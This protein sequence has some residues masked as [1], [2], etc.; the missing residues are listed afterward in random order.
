M[1]TIAKKRV[2]IIGAGIS[3]L[4][5]L[6]ECLAEGFDA[7]VL[8]SRAE[9]GGQWA[10]QAGP[11]EKGELQS[12][13]YDGVVLNSCRDTTA[14]SDFP[15]DP[16]RHGDYFSHREMHRYILDYA[17]HFG[18]H[19]HI[20]LRTKVL[21]CTQDAEGKW[22]VKFQEDGSKPQE[23]E[24]DVLIS[25][26][27]INS[28]PIIPDFKD[29]ESFRGEFLHSHYYRKPGRFEG[30]R[31]VLIGSGSAAIDLACELAPGCKE[32]HVITRRGTWVI[33]RYALGK[34]VE[35]WDS[36]ASQVWL[37]SSVAEWLNTT[38][39]NFVQG[40]HPKELQPD[41]K[42][43]QQNP[44]IRTEFI[45]KVRH[46]V[47]KV[48]RG[49][50]EN[51]LETGLKLTNGE[52]LG[53]DVII[54]CTGYKRE[55]P[56]LPGNVLSNA[57][58]PEFEADLYKLVIPARHDN[59]YFVGYIE[60]AGPSPPTM[61]AQARFAVGVIA[62]NITIP[63]GEKLLKEIR[64]WQAWHAK[65]YVRSERHVNTETYV[66]YID[67]L[68]APLG[69]NPTFGRLLGQVFTSGRALQSLSV[70]SAVYFDVTSSAQWRLLGRG[71]NEDLARETV[72][73]V[74][75]GKLESSTREKQL[76]GL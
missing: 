61:E 69:A 49:S 12:S 4:V 25:A 27:G 73:R 67:S 1:A 65:T 11:D 53:A 45:E 13:M 50:V 2:A 48:H 8:E 76:L 56:Y 59:L 15:I 72:L 10:Y 60:Q 70:L 43:M 26:T 6:K 32:V 38:L 16:A 24:Y 51:F 55:R 47:I 54:T 14:F 28:I 40:K 21:D 9:I 41:H 64:A 68:L 34:P 17:D 42:L 63:K 29:R 74:S 58:T 46:G 44:T 66:P 20:S 36:R 33:P 3:G 30:K 62:G 31:V 39:L 35:A 23:R 71:K 52:T 75:S 19:K 22:I 5:S 57:D 18:L 37:P 7:E